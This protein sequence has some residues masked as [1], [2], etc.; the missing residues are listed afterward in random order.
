MNQGW[1]YYDRIAKAG[2]GQTVLDYYCDRY[3]HSTRQD[4][5]QR[6]QQQQIQLNG[7][8]T[9]AATRLQMGQQL[10]YHR[11]P[12]VE[13]DVPLTV[14]ILHDDSDVLAINKPSGL[15]VLPGGGFLEHTVWWQL[16]H[17]YGYVD[18]YPIHR[19]GRGT[20]GVLLLAKHRAARAW[21][22]QQMRH[23]SQAQATVGS[24]D[25]RPALC[26]RYRAYVQGVPPQDQFTIT[27]PIGKRPHPVLGYL[28]AAQADGLPARS[29][30]WV[31]HRTATTALLDVQIATGRPHQ[32]RIHLAAAGFPLVGDPLYA[33]GGVPKVELPAANGDLPVPGDCGYRLHAME[34]RFCHPKGDW[35]AI[36][37][38]PPPDLVMP[39]T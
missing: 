24:L 20:S 25:A 14:D 9:T 7:Q 29:D 12:W 31:L 38:P 32:I 15:P 11:P 10:A 26:K 27:Q 21:L 37:A 13:P 22:S 3:P 39:L 4:W 2:V 6:I 30:C 18:T 5:Q 19:L 1:I 33:I 8:P 28:Y 36:I 23:T 16:R 17:R 35:Q 34:V